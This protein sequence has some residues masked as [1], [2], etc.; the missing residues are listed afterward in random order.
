MNDVMSDEWLPFQS[1]CEWVDACM[2]VVMPQWLSFLYFGGYSSLILL[3]VEHLSCIYVICIRS[4]LWRYGYD[5][6]SD[7]EMTWNIWLRAAREILF[8]QYFG[9]YY[10]AAD[11]HPPPPY[12]CWKII[13][14][15]VE[16]KVGYMFASVVWLNNLFEVIGSDNNYNHDNNNDNDMNDNDNDNTNA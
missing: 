11:V 9:S 6:S 8:K 3:V 12:L 7:C 15:L 1:A 14:P 16:L 4:W 13:F 10:A 2:S 5:G